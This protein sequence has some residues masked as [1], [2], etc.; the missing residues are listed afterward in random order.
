MRGKERLGIIMNKINKNNIKDWILSLQI[1]LACVGA[2]T[3]VPLLVGFPP[4]TALFTAGLGT[5]LFGFITKNKVPAFLGSSFAFIAPMIAITTQF[6]YEYSCGAFIIVGILYCLFAFLVYKVGINKITKWL[7]PHVTGTMIIII[8]LTLVPSAITNMQVNMPIAIISLLTSLLVLKFA[9]GFTKQLG[10]M[11]GLIVGYIV[12]VYFGLVDFSL[13][14]NVDIILLP[15]FVLPKFN[16]EAIMILAPVAIVTMLEHVGDIITLGTVT[17]KEYIKNPG[18]HRTLI[19]DGLATALAGLFGSVGNTTYG[20]STS[21]LALT[22]QSNPKITKNAAIL[23]L[24]LSLVGIFST[25]LQ[26]TPIFVIGG[27]SLQLYCMIAWIGVKNIKDNESYRSIKNVIVIIV[28][29]VIGLGS[30]VGLNISLPLGIVTLSGLSLA[31][32]VGILLNAILT[33]F[34]K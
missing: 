3:L 23:A 2:T 31:G 9:K 22:K 28:M 15:S 29:L 5:L 24:I 11:I 14:Q 34:F 33:K 12:S 16:F 8:G 19:A 7:P 27:I 26:T 32:V 10:I 17:N 25:G 6:G 1:L 4:S 13:L 20:E 21:V 30:L 18:L